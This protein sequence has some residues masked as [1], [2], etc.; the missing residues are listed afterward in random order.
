VIQEGSLTAHDHACLARQFPAGTPQP[1]AFPVGQ[2]RVVVVVHKSNP[3]RGIG[4]TGIGKA[5]SDEGKGTKWRDLGAG[6]TSLHTYGPSEE[7]WART[8]VQKQCMTR[9][10]D[11]APGVRTMKRL[12]F[13]DDLVACGD[14]KEV[15]AKVRADRGGLGF[16]AWEEQLTET[17]LRG[18]KLLPVAQG[19]REPAVTPSMQPIV[20]EDY[21]LAESV[22]LYLHPDAPPLA[23]EF[24]EF[25]VSSQGSQAA[26]H[27]GLSTNYDLEQIRAKERLADVKAGKGTVITAADLVGN[28]TLLKDLAMKF[29]EAK[30]A[31]RLKVEKGSSAETVVQSLLAG[32]TEVLLAREGG[33]EKRGVD[34]KAK[35]QSMELGRMAVAIVV[36]PENHVA[37]LPVDEVQ[38]ILGGQIKTW[39]EA[40]GPGTAMHVYGLPAQDPTTLLLRERLAEAALT[41]TLAANGQEAS[42]ASLDNAIQEAARHVALKVVAKADTAKVVAAVASDRAAIGF[43][44]RSQL[45]AVEKSVRIVPVDDGKHGEGKEAGS[46]GT[47]EQAVWLHVSAQASPVAKEFGA[48]VASRHCQATLAEHRL[49]VPGYANRS[50]QVAA[51]P[52]YTGSLAELEKELATVQDAPGELAL[53]DPDAPTRPQK[54]PE[55]PAPKSATQET[56]PPADSIRQEA[57]RTPAP[58]HPA[59]ESSPKAPSRS[60]RPSTAEMPDESERSAQRRWWL[61]ALGSAVLL[62]LVFGLTTGLRAK[63]RRH[64]RNP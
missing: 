38:G 4:L 22:V 45:T 37:S 55:H 21:P 28:E 23:R 9:W 1:E 35:P 36:H 15:L 42:A 58:S 3:I 10:E 62:A 48:F 46:V 57:S 52:P 60:L 34:G 16:F 33:W 6:G 18:V 27:M 63:S 29:T 43:V 7:A 51:G 17:D 64:S 8:F 30:A 11:T 44:D 14:A 2:R 47:L 39:P 32:S 61:G 12:A 31:V 13:R 25:V 26:K 53:A 41:R 19:E 56:S 50:R 24:C 49:L 54:S 20:A 5:L 40:H 59:A